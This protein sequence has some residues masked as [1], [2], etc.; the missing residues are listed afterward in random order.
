M[1]RGNRGRPKQVN[2][3]G[4]YERAECIGGGGLGR[5]WRGTLLSTGRAVAIKTYEGL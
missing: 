5:V 2:L 3:G 1:N 4:R